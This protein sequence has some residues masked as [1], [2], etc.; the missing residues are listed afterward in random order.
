M[1]AIQGDFGGNGGRTDSHEEDSVRKYMPPEL[2][3]CISLREVH[4]YRAPPGN[5][6][7]GGLCRGA[8]GLTTWEHG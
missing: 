6:R 2:E 5:P 7:K 3:D 1:A 4:I 8:G